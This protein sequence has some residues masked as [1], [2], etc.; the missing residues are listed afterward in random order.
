M[1]VK[2]TDLPELP[3]TT[4]FKV[5][6]PKSIEDR[7]RQLTDYLQALCRKETMNTDGDFHNFIN[8]EE[9]LH[10]KVSFNKEKMLYKFPDVDLGIREFVV[11]EDQKIVMACCS[12]ENL[13]TRIFSYWDNLKFSFLSDDQS[14]STV[15]AL[16]VFRIVSQDPWHV[17]KL[18]LK[19]FKSLATCIYFETS[20]NAL[21]VGLGNGKIRIFEIPKDFNFVKDVVYEAS[22]ISAHTNQ[23]TG[24]CMDS[25]LGYV[26]SIGRDGKLCVSD[27]T[28]CEVYWSKQF[29]KF[30]LTAL[31]HDTDNK[32]LLIGDSSGMIHVYSV[33]K[34]PPKRL[35]SLSTS[36]NIS[37]KSIT[38]SQDKTKMFAGTSEGTILCFQ[39]GPYG[40]EKKESAE[41]PYSL[42]G[43]TKCISLVWD[44]THKN[45][46]AGN[47]SGN[48][49]VW[50]P[51]ENRCAYV[52]NAHLHKVTSLYWN[53][54]ERKLITGSS[55][56]KI[57]VWQLPL[58]WIDLNFM[59]KVLKL[60]K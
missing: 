2:Y 6:D 55:D 48:V 38:C 14:H 15:G 33:K 4:W 24:V 26:Y 56:G 11:V 44:E 21:A 3:A 27:R 52:F 18:F 37:I 31:F 20:T 8:L 29:D 28:S 39:L 40:K 36:V 19:S 22:V 41:Y 16:V 32:R 53:R 49:A 30:E 51:E 13:Q 7:E 25:S 35:T 58:T 50:H 5:S 9:N 1:E 60:S 47:Q 59:A 54:E 23:I 12:E 17:E 34:Y 43:K 46:L 45:L 10:N 42:K 57:K